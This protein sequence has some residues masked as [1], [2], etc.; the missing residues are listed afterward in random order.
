MYLS[1]AFKGADYLQACILFKYVGVMRATALRLLSRH[2]LAPKTK[3]RYPLR[4]LINLLC[5]EDDD[6]A[7]EF[8]EN[9]GLYV[10]CSDDREPAVLLEGVQLQAGVPP[11]TR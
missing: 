1:R 7:I 5:F 3:T 4:E 2:F 11:V 9:C 6:D 10:D 8:A